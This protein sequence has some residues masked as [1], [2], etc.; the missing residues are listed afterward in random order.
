MKRYVTLLA[1]LGIFSIGVTQTVFA[2]TGVPKTRPIQMAD[3]HI[4]SGGDTNLTEQE[5]SEIIQA[6]LVKDYYAFCG[7]FLKEIAQEFGVEAQK[8]KEDYELVKDNTSISE[9][10][11][12]QKHLVQQFA[13]AASIGAWQVTADFP[14]LTKDTLQEAQAILDR[15]GVTDTDDNMDEALSPDQEKFILTKI[16]EFLVE[17]KEHNDKSIQNKE[18]SDAEQMAEY[19]AILK[20][21]SKSEQE[22][23]A[24]SYSLGFRVGIGYVPDV[25]PL[26][27]EVEKR[28]AA[29]EGNH[30]SSTESMD[31]TNSTVQSTNTASS[32]TSVGTSTST[33]TAAPVSVAPSTSSTPSSAPSQTTEGKPVAKRVLPRTGEKATT[34]AIHGMVALILSGLLFVIVK[35]RKSKNG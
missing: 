20:D 7:E 31:T 22:L 4:S 32:S 27:E 28:L 14:L 1:C 3:F 19:E 11:K 29:L 6:Q 35:N 21:P 8:A 16:K 5:L 34:F 30:T 12:L 23:L 24:A 25:T 18:A 15:Y 10:D 2:E 9:A 13:Q 33:S 17:K 26:L